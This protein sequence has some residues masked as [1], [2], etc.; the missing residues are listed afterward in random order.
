MDIP[1]KLPS[2]TDFLT[3]AEDLPGGRQEVSKERFWVG[4]SQWLKKREQKNLLSL[5]SNQL[6]LN[7]SNSF[8]P[9]LSH[10]VMSNLLV[11]LPLGVVE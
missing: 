10:G 1:L 11:N 7:A 9:G 8:L 5:L 4:L 3:I 6:K 2:A